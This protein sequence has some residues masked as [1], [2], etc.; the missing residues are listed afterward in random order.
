[1]QGGKNEKI[2][3]MLQELAAPDDLACENEFRFEDTAEGWRLH[4]AA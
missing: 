1:M 4:T 2:R 3:N